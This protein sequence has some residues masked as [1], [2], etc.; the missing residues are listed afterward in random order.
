MTRFL[1]ALTK[2]LL[3]TTQAPTASN[4][5]Y[6]VNGLQD[7]RRLVMQCLE[8]ISFDENSI[9]VMPHLNFKKDPAGLWLIIRDCI[10][11]SF[12]KNVLNQEDPTRK[13]IKSTADLFAFLSSQCKA[14]KEFERTAKRIENMFSGTAVD[15]QRKDAN[16]ARYPPRSNAHAIANMEDSVN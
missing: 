3:T 11:F 4:I 14:M 1:E 12:L 2:S 7:Y 9:E 15:Q 6:F 5:T 10:P 16:V 8:F 13:N